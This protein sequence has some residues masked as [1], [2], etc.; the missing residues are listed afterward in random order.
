MIGQAPEG[1]GQPN[2]QQQA[3]PVQP[4]P[5]SQQPQPMHTTFSAY[6]PTQ[7]RAAPTSVPVPRSATHTQ[8]P[9]LTTNEAYVHQSTPNPGS[10]HPLQQS[11]AMQQEPPAASPSIYFHHWVPPNEAKGLPQTPASKGEPL[12]AH[13]GSHISEGDY[14][15]SPRKRKAHGGH[16]PNPPPSAGPLYTSPSFSTTSSTSRKGAHARSRSNTSARE[17][18]DRPRSR[19]EADPPRLRQDTS[20]EQRPQESLQQRD[21]QPERLVPVNRTDARRDERSQGGP[22]P[23]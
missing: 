6:Q 16:Q 9:R 3:A 5:P 13:P 22:P 19:R 12:S 18:G 4:A 21:E 7:P 1:Y 8:L 20:D 17:S 14:K 11:Q 10:A 15:E 2:Y 23:A